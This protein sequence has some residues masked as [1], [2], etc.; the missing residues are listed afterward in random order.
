VEKD[1]LAIQRLV[2]KWRLAWEEGDLQACIA[3]YHPDYKRGGMDR[4]GWGKYLQNRFKSAAKRDIQLSDLHIQMNGSTA[5]VTFKQHY[6]T[7]T[8]QDYGVKTLHLRRDRNHWTILEENWQ[9]LS[10]QG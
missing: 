4:S 9:P 10:G 8:Y 2:E 1:E 7:E 6:Q 5:V 3:C